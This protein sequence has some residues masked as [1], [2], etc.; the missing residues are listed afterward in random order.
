[1]IIF[2]GPDHQSSTEKSENVIYRKV[3]QQQLFIAPSVY[4]TIK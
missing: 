3:E 2:K 4:E 1:M